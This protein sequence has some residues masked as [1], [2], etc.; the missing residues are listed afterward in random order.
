[1]HQ[2][3]SWRVLVFVEDVARQNAVGTNLGLCLSFLH[4]QGLDGAVEDE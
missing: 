4:T 2:I 3:F 1:M